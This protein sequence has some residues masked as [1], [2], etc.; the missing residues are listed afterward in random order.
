MGVSAHS[1]LIA[2]LL[3]VAG[4]GFAVGAI[5]L[6]LWWRRRGDWNQLEFSLLCL[7]A[8]AYDLGAVGSYVSATPEEHM[9][10]AAWQVGLSCL[11]MPLLG[12]LGLRLLGLLQPWHNWALWGL[13]G[14]LLAAHLILPEGILFAELLGQQVK[15]TPWGEALPDLLVVT[16]GLGYFYMSCILGLTFLLLVL[17]L[18][19]LRRGGQPEALPF[20]I[21]IGLLGLAFLNDVLHEVDLWGSF[22]LAE[23]AFVGMLVIMSRTLINRL[24]QSEHGLRHSLQ[25]LDSV[26]QSL[27]VLSEMTDL[28]AGQDLDWLVEEGLRAVTRYARCSWAVLA[29]LDQQGRCTRS[30]TFNGL[31]TEAEQLDLPQTCDQ[32]GLQA[33][34]SGKPVVIDRLAEQSSWSA[35]QLETLARH[36]L[37]S[38]LA[39]PL[40]YQSE[41]LGAVSLYFQRHGQFLPH[42]L[43][44]LEAI[45]HSISVALINARYSQRIQEEMQQR[46]R[47]EEGFR[48]SE[49]RYRAFVATS[50]EGIFRIEL[51]PPMPVTLGREEQISRIIRNGRIA[52]CNDEAARIMGVAAAGEA[53]GLS[54]AEFGFDRTALSTI[55]NFVD[56]G[57]QTRDQELQLTSADGQSRWVSLS[58]VGHV[59]RD[60]LVRI[61]GTQ[62]DITEKRAQQAMLLRIAEGISLAGGDGFFQSLAYAL[63]EATQASKV[64]IAELDDSL[65]LAITLAVATPTG[66]EQ[67]F[68]YPLQDS[69]CEDL[70]RLGDVVFR[71]SV[72]KRFPRDSLLEGSGIEA[73]VGKLLRDHSGRPLGILVAMFRQPL[74][75]ADGTASLLRIFAAR[76]EAELERRQDERSLRDSMVSLEYQALHDALTGLPNRDQI[77]K[78]LH[79]AILRNQGNQHIALLLMDI[80]RF[81]EINDT[82]GHE[83]GDVLLKMIGPRLAEALVGRAARVGRLGGDD[84]AVLVEEVEGEKDAADLAR[85]LLQVMRRPFPMEGFRFEL[86]GSIGISLYPTHG[87]DP[88]T[89]LRCAEVAMYQAKHSASGYLFYDAEQDPNSPVRLSLMAD[90]REAMETGQLFLAYQPKLDLVTGEVSGFEALIRWQHPTHGLLQPGEFIPLV[91]SSD[92]I[93][94]LTRWVVGQAV[95]QLRNWTRSG[96]RTSVSVN[97]SA[98]NLMDEELPGFL[99]EQVRHLDGSDPQLELEITESALITDPERALENMLQMRAMGVDLVIDDFGIGYSSLAYLRRLPVDALKID[100][101]FVNGMLEHHQAQVIVASTIHLAHD[102]G[103]KVVAEGIESRDVLDALKRLGCDQGQGYFIGKP[104]QSEMATRCLQQGIRGL[105]A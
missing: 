52:E 6:G 58:A 100:K 46:G 61:W 56:R 40:K 48:Q 45:G 91:E 28:H 2:G 101:S 85:S 54:L 23:F 95:S 29:L 99:R 24:Q 60:Q 65:N 41:V 16:S 72:A 3:L 17:A 19:S 43:N 63:R 90:L 53:E 78:D 86:Q 82:L 93:H 51:T 80:N 42:E 9:Y 50:A 5:H 77:D 92:L 34:S 88:G 22:Y 37:R 81:R 74:V 14:T 96:H 87:Q 11:F 15:I 104:M 70:I 64:F 79:R 31:Q 59:E 67:N 1:Y 89:L 39:V 36:G 18:R 69:P 62:R 57:Y 102:L 25:Q 75:D 71:G 66:P 83:A 10:A 98:R 35:S 94:A 44:T 8:V 73:Y 21:A 38:A 30:L 26:N 47:I 68:E 20:A 27:G 84:F 76:A 7:V 97:I 55:G 105:S 13:F 49:A 12:R 32:I 4:M 103:I 33:W